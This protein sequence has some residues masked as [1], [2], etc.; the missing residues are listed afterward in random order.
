[1]LLSSLTLA[2]LSSS[3]I[4]YSVDQSSV[5]GRHLLMAAEAALELNWRL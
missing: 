1:M 5:Q 3:A 4:I 2:A